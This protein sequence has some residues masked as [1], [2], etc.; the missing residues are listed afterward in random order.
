MLDLPGRITGLRWRLRAGF[1]ASSGS[2][3]AL[4]GRYRGCRD[5]DRQTLTDST[6][7]RALA[8]LL[9][10][11]KSALPEW[12]STELLINGTPISDAPAR[13]PRRRGHIAL[14]GE[15]CRRCRFLGIRAVPASLPQISQNP[16]TERHR[17][18]PVTP[19]VLCLRPL[20][21]T[22][23][24]HGFGLSTGS[25]ISAGSDRGCRSRRISLGIV[26]AWRDI[27]NMK[28]GASGG[29]LRHLS[30]TDDIL[31]TCRRDSTARVRTG[32]VALVF[33]SLVVGAQP[34]FSASDPDAPTRSSKRT[35]RPRYGVGWR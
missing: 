7:S 1:H 32:E 2:F 11:Q 12:G 20:Q 9:G 3:L 26:R 8:S 31:D 18:S 21:T 17:R 5:H 10:P 6:T 13:A 19:A 33:S 27:W 29:Q 25:I 30:R 4:C 14:L 34:G 16:E 22:W 24:P 35:D 15:R 23:S 28:V